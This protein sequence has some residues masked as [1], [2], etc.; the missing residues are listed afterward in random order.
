MSLNK[1]VWKLR[2]WVNHEY[3][4]WSLLSK[5]PNAIK[6]LEENQ[7]KINWYNLS[8]NPNAIQLLEKNLNK[9]NWS[10]LSS[11]TNANC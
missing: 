2:D 1:P 3:L 5:N 8:A 9:V 6:L 7:D 11:N 10:I 4:D